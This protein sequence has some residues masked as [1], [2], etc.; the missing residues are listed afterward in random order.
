MMELY[1]ENSNQ[2]RAIFP[3]SY[4][5]DFQMGSKYASQKTKIVK[6]KVRFANE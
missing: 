3:K 1:C 2:F 4:I 6:M 5:I